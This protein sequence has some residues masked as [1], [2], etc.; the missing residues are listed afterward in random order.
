MVSLELRGDARASK[1]GEEEEV[2]CP[3]GNVYSMLVILLCLAMYGPQG[4]GN[5]LP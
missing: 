4:N 1:A 5:A 2:L 3:D